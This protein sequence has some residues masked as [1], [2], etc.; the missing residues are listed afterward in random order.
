[1]SF[2]SVNTNSNAMAALQSLRSAQS[3]TL[4]AS[5][6][7]QTGYRVADAS[8]DAGVFAVAQQIRAD[9][10]GWDVVA[11][12]Q[13]RGLGATHV[14]LEGLETI[15]GLLNDLNRKVLEYGD[16]K[17]NFTTTILSNE[18]SAI[19]DQIDQVANAARFDGVTPL[20]SASGELNVGATAPGPLFGTH[21]FS[22]VSPFQV[23]HTSIAGIPPGQPGI[24][25][26]EY[27]HAGVPDIFAI[28][29]RG[30]VVGVSG[31]AAGSGTLAFQW[32]GGPPYTIEIIAGIGVASTA[33]Y[34]AAH[35]AGGV[36]MTP[37]AAPIQFLRDPQGGSEELRSVNATSAG[38]GLGA[39]EPL[40]AP[41]GPFTDI[42]N[43]IAFAR[44]VVGQNMSYFANK[45]KTFEATRE[46]AR[47]T[48]DSYTK[49][50][51]ATVDAD[52]GRDQARIEA[53]KAR[54]QL[55]LQGTSVAN[56]S[57]QA[58]LGLLDGLG[59]R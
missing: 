34:N 31:L 12:A 51:G 17:T 54:E 40:P 25:A 41:P 58:I 7:L 22:A 9:V 46:M 37:P 19:L 43:T 53:S 16:S 8:D 27:Q 42:L 14:A 28:A 1:M 56:R 47:T 29:Y 24:V 2:N 55:A 36:L 11:A 21:T 32:D 20:N 57:Q 15:S 4:D 35:D 45:A 49:G 52:I 3:T 10:G 48:M 5:K 26:V 6:R 38:I 59:R 23:Q 33:T 13:A 39:V 30:A 44:S 18:I 50:I